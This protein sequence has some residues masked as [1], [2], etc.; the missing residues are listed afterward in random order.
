MD[1]Q[2]Y[3]LFVTP[4]THHYLFSPS[5]CR[6]SSVLS[7]C[8]SEKAIMALCCPPVACQ[9]AG[10]PAVPAIRSH[11]LCCVTQR[12]TTDTDGNPIIPLRLAHRVLFAV[13]YYLLY[14]IDCVLMC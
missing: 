10:S 3:R 6:F 2:I 7:C 4:T 11:L 14:T 13:V 12:D 1:N 5:L 9:T 8:V